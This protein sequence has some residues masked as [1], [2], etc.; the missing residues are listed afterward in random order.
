MCCTCKG[1]WSPSCHLSF[2]II[3]YFTWHSLPSPFLPHFIFIPFWVYS[4]LLYYVNFSQDGFH[5]ECFLQKYNPK[6]KWLP[7]FGVVTS[8]TLLG[9]VSSF[10]KYQSLI[11]L[12]YSLSYFTSDNMSIFCGEVDEG[13]KI[14]MPLRINSIDLLCTWWI[15]TWCLCC[16]DYDIL[17]KGF[18]FSVIVF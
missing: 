4:N 11:S 13:T 17:P 3:Y 12:I 6:H 1:N 8:P 7:S 5:C 18:P 14:I 16:L 10:E 2:L 15:F 9:F